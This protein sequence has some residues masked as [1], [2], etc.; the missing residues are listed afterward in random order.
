MDKS[1][2]SLGLPAWPVAADE[3][4]SAEVWA[5]RFIE[6]AE[7][8]GYDSNSLTWESIRR[9]QA[10]LVGDNFRELKPMPYPPFRS[11]FLED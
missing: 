10:N 6:A 1:L 9:V 8:S 2:N 11:S 5:D 3:C 7:K 4:D